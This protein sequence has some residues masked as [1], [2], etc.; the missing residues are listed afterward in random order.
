MITVQCGLSASEETR[1][2]MWE[3]MQTKNTPL[4]NELN[5]K[6]NQHQ[7]FENWKKQG[8]I[9]EKEIR[10]LCETMKTDVRFQDQ[11]ARFYTSACYM[12]NYTYKSWIALQK[13]KQWRIDQ[14]KRWLDVV[15]SDFQLA[16]LS[17]FSQDMIFAK[18]Q[19]ILAQAIAKQLSEESITTKGKKSKQPKSKDS[20]A[21]ISIFDILFKTYDATED[22]L[23]RR[24]IIHLLKN[25][26]QVNE[27]E[28]LEEL[29]LRLGKKKI[30][31]NRL[32]EQVKSRLPKGRDP[33]GEKF[34]ISLAEAIS[35]PK[36]KLL[37]KLLIIMFI[38]IAGTLLT[39]RYIKFN[40]YI[41]ERILIIF[42]NINQN[43]G[44]EFTDWK[45]QAP[46]RDANLLKIYKSLPYPI[47]FGSTDD[48]YWS[49]E[50]KKDTK[51]SQSVEQSLN[52]QENIQSPKGKKRKNKKKVKQSHICV[53]F[54][55]KGLSSHI[56]RIQCDRRQLP[57]FQQFLK[58]WQTHKKLNKE[59][60][61]SMGLFLLR[62]A[63]LLW[64]E[65]TR[66][67]HK[68]KRKQSQDNQLNESSSAKLG[69]QEDKPWNTH[70]LFLHCTID[71]RLL[72]AEGT[73]K[74]RQEKIKSSQKECS[75]T[76]KEKTKEEVKINHKKSTLN[77]LLNLSPP[78]PSKPIYEGYPNIM[79][80]VSFSY[81][82]L[83]AVAVVEIKTGK[84]LKYYNVRQ[85]LASQ[86]IKK[87]LRHRSIFQLRFEKYRLVNRLRMYK[88]QNL[89]P[90]R[91]KKRQNLPHQSNNK[92]QDVYVKYH[93]ESHLGEYLDRLLAAR[94]VELS[95]KWQAST[96]V[97][98][99]LKNIRES[100]E[101]E[102]QA[103]AESKF[104]QD[105]TSQ[106]NYSKI[107]RTNFHRWSYS[108]LQK[109]IQVR[110]AKQ[111]ISTTVRRQ[112][113]QGSLQ[114]KAHGLV[115]A[116]YHTS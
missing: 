28:N 70:R 103:R 47:I 82:K 6:I 38:F 83:L 67:P 91:R 56:F 80:S 25:N 104:P 19:E 5:Q 46:T 97:I 12:V 102:I 52:N 4:I 106:R 66:K 74:V 113:V 63:C 84:V 100:I 59:E 114:E 2:Y 41:I 22:I 30:E 51:V 73:E 36:H 14:K 75:K 95:L 1:R 105:K 54:K 87:P 99:E 7:T 23:T 40:F 77:Y 24:A 31:I 16:K 64:K 101:S 107:F 92:K 76:S 115:M 34:K 49:L 48:L 35:L 72:T 11:P 29:S 65:N 79:L 15:E 108:R 13:D 78:R 60:K 109:S 89:K 32:E 88:Q 93:S 71:T 44:A 96:I 62:S 58:D 21:N 17:D 8:F 39:N 50:Q 57:I 18:A 98:P 10:Q 68:K 61:F 94:I 85:L 27:Q 112:P 45:N 43:I 53:S 26:S 3:L 90:L 42:E 116:T 20:T 37:T 69:Q 110:A 55:S 81:Q 9:P 33:N 111:G 86:S